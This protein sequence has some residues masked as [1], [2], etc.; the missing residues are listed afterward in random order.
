MALFVRF[1]FVV[2][3][4]WEDVPV[5][6]P[7]CVYWWHDKGTAVPVGTQPCMSSINI[8]RSVGSVVLMDYRRRFKLGCACLVPERKKRPQNV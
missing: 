4:A 7:S 5:L 8:C 6:A 3:M 2:S 1:L